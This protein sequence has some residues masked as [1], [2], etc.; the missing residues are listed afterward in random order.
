MQNQL[1][2][3]ARELKIRNYSPRAAKNYFYAPKE[4]FAFKK[5][6]LGSLDTDNI[7]NLVKI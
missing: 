6:N 5:Y 4:Y 7:R 2:Q 3:T 1:E